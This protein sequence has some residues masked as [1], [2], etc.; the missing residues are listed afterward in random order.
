MRFMDSKE[1][2]RILKSNHPEGYVTSGQ[3]QSDSYSI[4]YYVV[5][6]AKE[7]LFFYVNRRG[8]LDMDL[9]LPWAK[10]PDTL[11]LRKDKKDKTYR[12]K[13]ELLLTIFVGDKEGKMVAELIEGR[14]KLLPWMKFP[15][16]R[17][18]PGYRSQVAWKM[19]MASMFYFFFLG[20]IFASALEDVEDD[21]KQAVKQPVVQTE[22]EEEAKKSDSEAA[23]KKKAEEL[24]AAK[25]AK[26]AEEKKKAALE[27]KKAEQEKK[28]QLA[29]EKAKAE[30]KREAERKA[31]IAAQ[32]KAKKKAAAKL[33]AQQ[34]AERKAQ[35]E[36]AQQAEDEAAT[37]QVSFDNCDDLRTEYPNGVP[38][39]HPAYDSNMDRDKD[40]FACER[41]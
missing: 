21:T 39:S 32:E 22:A 35:E 27:K 13:E 1:I 24:A 11:Y 8:S 29:K 36:A 38:S 15:W 31:K 9:H 2:R 30:A 28:K 17:K 19:V 12:T 18:I 10:V 40:N 5:A 33:A 25:K 14:R 41:N 3:H 4:P 23:K 34:E 6:T 7:G 20:M 37:T 16:Y 26:E